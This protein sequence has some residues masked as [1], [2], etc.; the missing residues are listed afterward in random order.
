MELCRKCF[1]IRIRIYDFSMA[2]LLEK[3]S[4]IIVIETC[5]TIKRVRNQGNHDKYTLL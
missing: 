4:N 5:V 1:L 2:L 3:V